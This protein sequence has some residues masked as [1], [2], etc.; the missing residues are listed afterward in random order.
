[1]WRLSSAT[2]SQ[3]EKRREMTVCVIVCHLIIQTIPQVATF[4]SPTAL[5]LSSPPFHRLTEQFQFVCVYDPKLCLHICS[6]CIRMC[7]LCSRCRCIQNRYC[8]SLSVVVFLALL[9]AAFARLWSWVWG[10]R[11]DLWSDSSFFPL[12]LLFTPILMLPARCSWS[13]SSSL[14]Q[15]SCK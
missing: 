8:A 2:L 5:P 7:V 3:I 13:V 11:D 15:Q 9:P 12:L 14:L 4:S 10:M 1:M 6:V